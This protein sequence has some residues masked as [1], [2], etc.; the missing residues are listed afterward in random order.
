MSDAPRLLHPYLDS[1]GAIEF[2]QMQDALD[3][4]SSVLWMLADLFGSDTERYSFLDSESARRGMFVQ[5]TNIA[6]LLEVLS[7]ALDGKQEP[8]G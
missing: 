3:K 6:N 8:C 2:N 5:L 7:A 4:S 1:Q